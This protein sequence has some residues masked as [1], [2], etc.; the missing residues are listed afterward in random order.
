MRALKKDEPSLS[1]LFCNSPNIN[2]GNT[3]S[4]TSASKWSKL[5]V[6]VYESTF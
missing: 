3:E 2:M 6:V 1:I 5:P 4:T